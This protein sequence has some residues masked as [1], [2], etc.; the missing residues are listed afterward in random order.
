MS[1][2]EEVVRDFCQAFSRCNV[3]EL[4]GFFAE[5]AVYHN[6]PIPAVRGKAAIEATLRQFIDPNGSAEFEIK[7]LACTAGT[8]LTERVDRFLL[9]GKKIEI[10]VMGA[11][12]VGP[13]GK[14]RAWR[15]YFD[16]AQF[17][18]QLV[19]DP[20]PSPPSSASTE[21]DAQDAVA[22]EGADE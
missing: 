11:F 2:A 3:K 5:D 16:M 6:I 21:I 19:D 9:N 18:K 13:D 10:P 14:I 8:V 20:L 22:G 12:E 15:D 1:R 7:A 4:L 17:T